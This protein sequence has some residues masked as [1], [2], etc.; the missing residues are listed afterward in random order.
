MSLLDDVQRENLRTDLPEFRP[1]DKIRV[2]ERVIEGEK[3]R[4]QIFEGVVIRKRGEMLSSTFTVRKKSLG[5]G[6]E[7][8]YPL[9][10]P[11]IQKV[12]VI[13][14]GNV[15]RANLGYLRGM[16][17]KAIRDKLK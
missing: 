8:I 5:V 3:E 12:E 16:K 7:K 13:R 17:D 1:G 10:S 6:V 4:V 15:R 11:K 2:F 14:R 9:H